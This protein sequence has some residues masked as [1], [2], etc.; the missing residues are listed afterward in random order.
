MNP[1]MSSLKVILMNPPSHQPGLRRRHLIAAALALAA[2]ITAVPAAALALAAPASHRAPQ[3][4]TAATS[5][6]T[7]H[8]V[9]HE[10]Q[11]KFL[12]E[13]GSETRKSSAG[14]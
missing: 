7:I 14:P 4:A 6:R 1:M 5:V 2:L 9:A 11:H 12:N 13:G 10:T 8:L 3:P